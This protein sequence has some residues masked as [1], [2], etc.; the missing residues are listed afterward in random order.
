MAHRTPCGLAPLQ[1]S[2]AAGG[3]EYLNRWRPA[4][5]LF[6]EGQRFLQV[7]NLHRNLG[8]SGYARNQAGR[9][10]GDRTTTQLCSITVAVRSAR[11]RRRRLALLLLTFQC[12][13]PG[14]RIGVAE[15]SGQTNTET[16]AAANTPRACL[17]ACFTRFSRGRSLRNIAPEPLTQGAGSGTSTDRGANPCGSACRNRRGT[18]GACR[19]A[20]ETY[21]GRLVPLARAVRLSRIELPRCCTPMPSSTRRCENRPQPRSS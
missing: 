1:R 20:T 6:G 21:L 2:C 7:P 11:Y 17:A 14:G 4:F 15:W 13:S 9:C 8:G 10:H 19:N 5:E 12:F 3:R 18:I 16:R